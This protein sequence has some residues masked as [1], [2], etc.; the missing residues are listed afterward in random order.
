MKHQTRDQIDTGTRLTKSDSPA[1]TFE[2]ME[3]WTPVD[4][5]PHA[6][7][8]VRMMNHDLGVRLYAV[9]ALLDRR[10]FHVVENSV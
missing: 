5:L 1:Y 3:M 2:V 4:G 6:R 9:S 7:T 8:R 10:L